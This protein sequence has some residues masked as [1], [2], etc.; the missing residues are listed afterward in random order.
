MKIKFCKISVLVASLLLGQAVF[1]QAPT[2]I[3]KV[4]DF[5]LK[6]IKLQKSTLDEVQKK[7]GK[8][9]LRPFIES[10]ESFKGVCYQ[11]ADGA[12]LQ[13]GSRVMGDSK[14]VDEIMLVSAKGEENFGDCMRS[15]KF[16]SKIIF[17]NGI[18]LGVSRDEITKKL[19][20]PSMEKD[21]RLEYAFE[22]KGSKEAPQ[23]LVVSFKFDKD[24]KMES[25]FV[26]QTTRK[27]N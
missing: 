24:K 18:R 27:N 11:S 20:S 1:A 26:V 16:A 21:T 4:G 10:A 3:K 13:F 2:E 6:G 22:L 15:R 5:N 25:L 7:F 23:T 17:G 8:Q 12:K 9:E 14:V 19:G